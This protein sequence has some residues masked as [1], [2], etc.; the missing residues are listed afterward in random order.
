MTDPT[1]WRSCAH[2]HHSTIGD[3]FCRLGD[4]STLSCSCAAYVPRA[5][6]DAA[7]QAAAEWIYERDWRSRRWPGEEA[8][9]RRPTFAQLLTG[10]TMRPPS[11]A[12]VEVEE[13]KR[14]LADASD[15]IAS[16]RPIIEAEV[17][18]RIAAEIEDGCR[19]GQYAENDPQPCDAC[20][21]AARIARGAS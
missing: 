1:A 18:A 11:Y 21:E 13:G 5:M 9:R 14:R 17:R 2:D 4:G 10:E 8:M 15:L 19:A 16:L 3:D 6:T 7:T 20:V 12:H